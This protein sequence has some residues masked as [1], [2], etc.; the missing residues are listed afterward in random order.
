MNSRPALGSHCAPCLVAR[1]VWLDLSPHA[2]PM[3]RQVSREGGQEPGG[4]RDLRAVA[5]ARNLRQRAIR[6]SIAIF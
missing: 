1:H 2:A 5:A 3:E 6:T 4:E